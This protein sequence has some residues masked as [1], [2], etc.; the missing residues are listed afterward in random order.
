MN[1]ER[2]SLLGSSFGSSG[3]SIQEPPAPWYQRWLPTSFF[4]RSA[5]L[6]LDHDPD[7]KSWWEWLCCC[8]CCCFSSNTA[9]EENDKSADCWTNLGFVF[10][11]I[12]SGVADAYW[13]GQFFD[14]LTGLEA[15]QIGLSYY[16]MGVG[17]TFGMLAAWGDSYTR[18]ALNR[19]N[20]SDTGI[21][22]ND[23]EI[24]YHLTWKQWGLLLAATVD[25]VGNRAAGL[26]LAYNVIR[27]GKVLHWEGI[28][29]N[30]VTSFIGFFASYADLRSVKQSMED[31]NYWD[32]V[33]KKRV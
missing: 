33:E 31:I 6:D 14:D 12:G 25:N 32:L 11:L 2:S 9:K 10:N 19:V 1:R 30:V 20:Q 16:G 29:S 8:C 7:A 3:S 21:T 18:W 23:P 24:N 26:Q 4:S 17:F 5:E 22:K 27:Y 15:D 28:V 13:L